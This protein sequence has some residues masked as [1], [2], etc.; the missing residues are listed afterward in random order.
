MTHPEHNPGKA[1][2]GGS[3]STGTGAHRAQ[4]KQSRKR[5]SRAA[6]AKQA[7]PRHSQSKGRDQGQKGLGTASRNE[8]SKGEDEYAS[9]ASSQRADRALAKNRHCSKTHKH[10][11]A[12][13][14][15]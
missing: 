15:P 8:N 1:Q 4:V 13:Q 3:L 6:K 9:Q 10:S 12:W 2:P 11:T 14:G 7:D 5:H